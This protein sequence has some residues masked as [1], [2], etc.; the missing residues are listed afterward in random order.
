[1]KRQ[2][3]TPVIAV[4]AICALILIGIFGLKIV[5][6]GDPQVG[7]SIPQ[8]YDKVG[9]LAKQSGGDFSKLSPEDQKLLNDMSRGHGKKFLETQY[10]KLNSP[11]GNPN[12]SHVNP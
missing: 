6:G 1:M 11:G 12:P 5:N 4:V 7:P 10:A 8:L 2:I 3:P 9:A